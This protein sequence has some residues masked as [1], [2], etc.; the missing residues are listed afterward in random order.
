MQGH[1]IAI[2]FIPVDDILLLSSQQKNQQLGFTL[3][4]LL[5]TIAIMSLLIGIAVGS[6]VPMIDRSR[7]GEAVNQL[8][9]EIVFARGEAIKLGGWVEICGIDGGYICTDS[10]ENGWMVYL[11]TDKNHEYNSGDE[12]LS[13]TEQIHNKLDVTVS[14]V[15]TAMD[16]TLTFN[17]RGYPD[18]AV[19]FEISQGEADYEFL[20]QTTGNIEMLQ[21]E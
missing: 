10:F 2:Q 7:A 9:T 18:R 4:E 13:W 21:H 3:V 6:F 12:V 16:N 11:D 8:R 1:E 17:H 20:L 5:V 19:L 14:D 15:G